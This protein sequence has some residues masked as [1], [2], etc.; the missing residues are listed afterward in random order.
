MAWDPRRVCLVEDGRRY[1]FAQLR[2]YATRTARALGRAGVGPGHLVAVSC[3]R[4]G[5]AVAGML[6]AWLRG[7]AYVPVVPSLPTARAAAILDTARPAAMLVDAAD[8]FTAPE[9]D[10]PVDG[11]PRRLSPGTAYVI[12][13]SGST[14]AP[15]GVV[16]GHA[17]LAA[18]I[19]WHRQVTGLT[20]GECA[21]QVADLGFDASVWEIWG[22]LANGAQ[23][24]VPSMD[25]LLDPVELQAFLLRHRVR[26]GFVPTGLMPGLLDL[27]WPA[28]VPMRVLFTGGD[29]LTRWPEQRHPFQLVNAYGPTECT[30][31]ATAHPL[32]TSRAEAGAPPPIGRPLPHVETAVVGPDGAPADTGELWL[33]G[34]AV[35][36]GYLGRADAGEAFTTVGSRRWYRTGD[37]V[38]RDT[39][40]VLHYESRLDDQIQI[41][42]RRTEPAEIVRAILSLPRVTDAVVFTSQTA[43][44]EVRLAAAVA[45]A[46]V[47]RAA[48]QSHLAGLVLPFMIPSEVLSMDTLPVTSRGKFDVARLRTALAGAVPR[49]DGVLAH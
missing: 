48:V 43:G 17:G 32:A 28:R 39:N 27:D 1:S 49:T 35:A 31:V 46:G 15:K 23:L 42:G 6:A 3:S 26:A 25:Q 38:R 33:A 14:G 21:S 16:L 34:V 45:P 13:T 9:V 19:R 44:G 41:G 12:F 5:P 8:P 10:R 29:R 11:P 40:G 47:S 4:R 36:Q 22:A 7:A 24:A 37:L 20:D 30:V 2:D 18:L